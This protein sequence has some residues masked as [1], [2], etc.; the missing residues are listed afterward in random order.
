M[1]VAPYSPAWSTRIIESVRGLGSPGIDNDAFD[2]VPFNQYGGLGKASQLF[3]AEL[4]GILTELNER[5]VA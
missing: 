1:R 3:G 5:L 2:D 4:P